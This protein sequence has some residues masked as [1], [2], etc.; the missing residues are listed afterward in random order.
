M[1]RSRGL[2]ATSFGALGALAGSVTIAVSMAAGEDDTSGEASLRETFCNGASVCRVV[3]TLADPDASDGVP[4]PVAAPSLGELLLAH[5]KPASA[6]PA[7]T[8]A[9]AAT[10]R[11]VHAYLGPCPSL[12]RL[13]QIAP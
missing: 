7:A 4:Q 10:G 2:A 1:R 3:N 6:C 5:G 12:A 11:E 8:A 13:P 9:Y